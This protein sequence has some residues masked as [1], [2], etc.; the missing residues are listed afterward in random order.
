MTLNRSE[1]AICALSANSLAWNTWAHDSLTALGMAAIRNPLGDRLLHFINEPR[2]S[3][4]MEICL[5]ISTKLIK[6][7]YDKLQTAD[8]AY[9][10]FEY[11]NSRHCLK[12]SGR[13][14]LNKEQLECDRC[15]GTGERPI[16]AEYSQAVKDAIAILL[17][18]ENWMELQLK[19][20][21]APN[22]VPNHKYAL[23]EKYEILG[24]DTGIARKN[25]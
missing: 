10:A 4:A 16:P 13:G 3:L 19:A 12:C 7:G 21:L 5:M 8:N 23:P 18:A 15:G 2:A 22:Y 6:A 9:Q 24:V 1:T 14:V 20:R 25:A 17:D 11:W